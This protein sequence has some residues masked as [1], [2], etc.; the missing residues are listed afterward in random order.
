MTHSSITLILLF[1]SIKIMS[2][3][4]YW[5]DCLYCE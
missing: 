1:K 5:W 3:H 2:H 4:R